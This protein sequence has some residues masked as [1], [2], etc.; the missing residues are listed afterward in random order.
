MARDDR[1]YAVYTLL[2]LNAAVFLL[3]ERAGGSTNMEALDRMGAVY[4]S[5]IWRGE[6]WRFLTPAFLHIGPWHLLVNSLSLYFIGPS[7]ERW[8]G[9][10]RFLGIYFLAVLGG[11]VSCLLGHDVGSAGASGGLFGL[12][13]GVLAILYYEYYRDWGAVLRS[14]VGGQVAFWTG[15]NFL[16]GLT[17]PV[18]NWA[19]FG[20]WVTGG[21]ACAFYASDF[22]RRSSR[23]RGLRWGAYGFAVLLAAGLAYSIFPFRNPDFQ[24]DR[25]NVA[26]A[27]GDFEAAARL[28]ERS[29]ALGVRHPGVTYN[30]AL[31]SER[32]GRSG[33][34]RAYLETFVTMAP[35]KRDA[36]LLLADWRRRAG[37]E[38]G[39]RA[40]AAKAAG[41]RD[42][43]DD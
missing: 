33:E 28:Y 3:Q 43:G 39:A 13:G 35:S 19:H 38:A 4:R 42:S 17:A 18:C 25:G 29:L 6:Y 16:Y 8:A 27:R 36:W 41:M 40:A 26:Y 30:L 24:F 5:A 14:P 32:L 21:M 1:P 9:T 23:D 15:L 22:L 31:A 20:G 34:A 12:L 11:S 2:V 37:D 10:Y 7:L